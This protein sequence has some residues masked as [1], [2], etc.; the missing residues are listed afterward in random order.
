MHHQPVPVE[1]IDVNEHMGDVKGGR[2]AASSNLARAGKTSVAAI[3]VNG[4]TGAVLS[5][6]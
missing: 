4:P 2:I 3:G 6:G 5:A 1:L